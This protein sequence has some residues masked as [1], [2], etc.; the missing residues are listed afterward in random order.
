[1]WSDDDEQTYQNI[2]KMEPAKKVPSENSKLLTKAIQNELGL[3]L[4]E[5]QSTTNRHESMVKRET[6]VK[7]INIDEPLNFKCLQCNFRN[8]QKDR[9]KMHMRS[10]TEDRPFKCYLCEKGFK[11]KKQIIYHENIHLGLKA[12]KCNSCQ[13]KFANNGDLNRHFKYKHTNEKPYHC[14]ECNFKCVEKAKLERH[15]LI[16]TGKRPHQ[17]NDCSYAAADRFTLKRHQRT[18]TGVKP[19]ECDICRKAFN[20]QNSLKDHRRIHTGTKPFFKC[21][22]CPKS[23]RRKSDLLVH[24]RKFHSNLYYIEDDF[25]KE[26]IQEDVKLNCLNK[27][28]EQLIYQQQETEKQQIHKVPHNKEPQQEQNKKITELTS[29]SENLEAGGIDTSKQKLATEDLETG[30]ILDIDEDTFVLLLQ[31]QGKIEFNFERKGP[32]A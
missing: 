20:Q 17:C 1:M 31:K 5:N 2:V 10:H 26:E 6:V 14:T 15:M 29:C 13:S 19:Y 11:T 18:H 32:I 23:A 22:S 28:K 16:H 3:V 30:E 24:T 25:Q 27:Q 21:V 7:Q 8:P 12:Y 4:D 9:L